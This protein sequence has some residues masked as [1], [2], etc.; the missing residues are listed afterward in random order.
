MPAVLFTSE[1]AAEMG[2]RSAEARRKRDEFV[3][4]TISAI[5]TI[6]AHQRQT[7]TFTDKSLLRVRIQINR[8]HDQIDEAITGDPKKLKELAESLARLNEIERQ[9]SGR[10]LPGTLKPERKM[11]QVQVWSEPE[12]VATPQQIDNSGRYDPS[13]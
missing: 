11:K 2:R 3:R 1:T 5:E 12:P 7:P 4:S 6:P 9:L 8:I 10:P 13:I